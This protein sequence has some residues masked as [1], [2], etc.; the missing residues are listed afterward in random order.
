V[1]RLRRTKQVA[2]VAIAALAMVLAV[3]APSQARGGGGHSFGVGHSGGAFGHHGFDGPHG[4][5]GHRGFDRFRHDR[6]DRFGHD[7]FLFGFGF[8]GPVYPYYGYYGYGTPA[9]W[10]YCPAYNAYYPNVASCPEAWIPVP[11][12]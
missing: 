5:D 11:A 9:Y 4:F 2:F 10:Y 8:G 12:S 7:R 1:N 3:N 6:F